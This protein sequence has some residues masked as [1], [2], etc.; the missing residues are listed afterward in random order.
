MKDPWSL[1]QMTVSQRYDMGTNTST[2]MF[3]KPFGGFQDKLRAFNS[4]N[5]HNHPMALHLIYL[6]MTTD[7]FNWYIDF[8][9]QR[10]GEFVSC[11]K[12][13]TYMVLRQ[14]D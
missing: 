6:T 3:I 9:R 12:A 13:L 14:T 10:L 4:G 2:W 7:E 5:Y 1:R 11:E 8:L